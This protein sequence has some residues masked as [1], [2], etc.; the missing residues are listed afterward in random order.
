MKKWN[1]GG[2]TYTQ[3]TWGR[4]VKLWSIIVSE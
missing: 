1:V 3:K 2:Y 4:H